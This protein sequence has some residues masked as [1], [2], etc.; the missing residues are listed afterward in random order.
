MILLQ[1]VR[2]LLIFVRYQVWFKVVPD[3]TEQETIGGKWGGGGGGG[4]LLLLTYEPVSPS[5]PNRSPSLPTCLNLV[6][7]TSSPSTPPPQSLFCR[8]GFVLTFHC[9]IRRVETLTKEKSESERLKMEVEAAY[10]T[11]QY[12]HDQESE[13]RRVSEALHNQLK[14]QITRAEE[15]LAK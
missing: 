1:R 4:S 7:A 14:E 15:K 12:K 9:F 5:F 2:F 3:R 6:P 8:L 11:L 13:A 10:R